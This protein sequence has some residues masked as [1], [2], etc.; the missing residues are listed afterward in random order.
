MSILIGD[1]MSLYTSDINVLKTAS[2]LY[3]QTLLMCVFLLLSNGGILFSERAKTPSIKHLRHHFLAH[4]L[5]SCKLFLFKLLP[6]CHS[7][8]LTATQ[9]VY[10]I[11]RYFYYLVGQDQLHPIVICFTFPVWARSTCS[12]WLLTSYFYIQLPKQRQLWQMMEQDV[13]ESQRKPA[14]M[15]GQVSTTSYSRFPLFASCIV[16]EEVLAQRGKNQSQ[17][18]DRLNF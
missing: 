4:C 9:K 18:K 11:L 7:V 3:Q 1:S 5:I 14:N 13:K 17:G 10:S 12:I 16:Q 6:S 2:S 15:S 8:S